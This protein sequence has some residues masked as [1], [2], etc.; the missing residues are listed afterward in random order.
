M[1]F[2]DSWADYELLDCSDGQ[3]LERW[4]NYIL[5]RPDPQVLWKHCKKHPMWKRADAV[6]TRSG[7]GGGSWNE[8]SLP[9]EWKIGYKNLTFSI[10]PMGFK[11]T[12]L[13]PEQAVNW[14]WFHDLIKNAGRPVKVLNL[15]AYTGGAT[16]WWQGQGKMRRFPGFPTRR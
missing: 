6:Y 7:S 9:E 16:A 14:D 15:F 8:N 11:H 10:R 13:F 4:G 12:G 2:S 1:W 3:R 5:V